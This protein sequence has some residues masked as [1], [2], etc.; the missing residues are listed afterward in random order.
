MQTRVIWEKGFG[1]VKVGLHCKELGYFIHAALTAIFNSSITCQLKRQAI[2]WQPLRA[3]S[4]NLQI[5]IKHG[6]HF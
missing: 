3:V 5:E 2:Q 4:D 1:T 6:N